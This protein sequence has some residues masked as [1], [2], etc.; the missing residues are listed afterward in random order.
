MGDEAVS[1]IE[2][3][4]TDPFFI[5][6]A[7]NAP[8]VPLQATD[9]YLQRFPNLKGARRTYAAMISAVD[10]AV[11]RV[12]EKLRRENLDERTLIFFLSDNGGHPIASGAVQ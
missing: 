1:Y 2:R 10:D 3:H 7:F 9:K 5:Y 12:T 4:K 6:L 11:G 8:H